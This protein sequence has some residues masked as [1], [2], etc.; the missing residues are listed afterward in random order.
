MSLSNIIS[1][2]DTSRDGDGT[3]LAEKCNRQ[4]ATR[5]RSAFQMPFHPAG[6]AR[7]ARKSWHWCPAGFATLAAEHAAGVCVSVCLCVCLSAGVCACARAVIMLQRSLALRTSNVCDPMPPPTSHPVWK[8]LNNCQAPGS[9]VGNYFEEAEVTRKAME[10]ARPA[11]GRIASWCAEPILERPWCS[12]RV[13]LALQQL[14]PRPVGQL[15]YSPTCTEYSRAKTTG[16]TI[17][18][19]SNSIVLKN[20]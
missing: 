7:R 8:T 3:V 20:H 9:A 5:A 16:I 1:A 17:S 14:A 15:D 13:R 11:K 4:S 19:Y 18:E 10:L 2:T 6:N 12:S